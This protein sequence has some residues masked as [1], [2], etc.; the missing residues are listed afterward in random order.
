MPKAQTHIY[1]SAIVG[2]TIS[3]P[4]YTCMV[5]LVLLIAFSAPFVSAQNSEELKFLIFEPVLIETSTLDENLHVSELT[6][7]PKSES[8]KYISGVINE[9]LTD[10]NELPSVDLNETI[11][12]YDETIKN[13]ELQGGAYEP[14]LSQ[15]LLSMGMLYQSQND[16]EQ[17]LEYMD[18]ALHVNR[19]N[20]GLYNLEQEQIIGEKIKS[21]IALGDLFDADMQQ[22]YLFNLKRKIYGNVHI[23]LLPALNEYAEWNIFAFDSRLVMNPHFNYAAK[24]SA[25]TDNSVSNS[26]GAESSKTS[27]LVTAQNIY[28]K[29]IQILINNYGDNDPRLLDIEKKL[30]LTNYFFSTN[31]SGS[32]AFS[33]G[34]SLTLVMNSSQSYYSTSQVSTN[35]MGYRH[36]REALERR[37]GYMQTMENIAPEDI[38]KAKIELGDWLT[39]FKKRVGGLKLYEEAYNEL[40][41]TGVAQEKIDELFS[42]TFPETIPAFIDYP[43]SRASH[44]IPENQAL[45]YQ[46]W[47]DVRLEINRYGKPEDIEI[48]GRSLNT[49]EPIENRLLRL[50]RN[51]TSFRPRF[52]NDEPIDRET[53]EARY[54]YSY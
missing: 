15:E 21:L 35:S 22:E 51:S 12:A 46:G 25:F 11:A 47:F 9:S 26:I 6:S 38:V 19:V 2:T 41:A 16:H 40:K 8:P 27:R 42:P 23:D 37:L 20:L 17:A 33:N 44:N 53:Y 31:L 36:G 48:I 28:R 24:S 29:I 13:L 4:A 10:T 14:A 49:T 1:K 7:L 50:L 34:E 45:S 32:S 5:I 3:S 54:Y 43:Y 52:S 39:I 18:Q 30:A